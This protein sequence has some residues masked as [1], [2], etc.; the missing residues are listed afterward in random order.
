[1]YEFVAAQE[2]L[3]QERYR[4]EPADRDP[5][6][7]AM[8]AY[9]REAAAAVPPPPPA[10]KTRGRKPAAPTEIAMTLFDAAPPPAAPARPAPFALSV[11]ALVSFARCPRQFHWSVI[12]PLPRRG[13]T[14]ASIG[15]AVHR[16]IETRHGPQGV[17]VDH[18]H[19]GESLGVVAG[20][21]QSF[22]ASAYAEHAPISAEAQFDLFVGGHMVRGRIDAVY[23]HPDGVIELVDFKT[24]RPP[25]EGDPSAETQLMIYAIAAADSFKFEP[26]LL[27]ASF[28]YLQSDGSPAVT[29]DIEVSPSRVAEARAWLADTITRIDAHTST[30]NA[31]AWC[32]RCDF[33]AVCPAAPA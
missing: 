31:G 28:V 15:T 32:A 10:P 19:E 17:L 22:S 21:R 4:N 13:S 33:R 11:S 6:V 29:V 23:A 5:R 12:R 16:W 14:A 3:V 8:E 1:L 9:R 20:L 7:V 2:D 26:D 27:K 30:T 24:G 18:E 25:A